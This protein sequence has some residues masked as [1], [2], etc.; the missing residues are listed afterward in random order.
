MAVAVILLALPET[1]VLL[2][3]MAAVTN[4]LPETIASAPLLL[5]AE[6]VVVNLTTEAEA[7]TGLHLDAHH[8]PLTTIPRLAAVVEVAGAADIAGAAPT[9]TRPRETAAD[10]MMITGVQMGLVGGITMSPIEDVR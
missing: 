4:R 1:I 2:R 3:T 7:A 10:M 5:P 8:P 9:N 6:A